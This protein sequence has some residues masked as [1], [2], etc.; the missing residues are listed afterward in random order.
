MNTALKAKSMGTSLWFTPEEL[1]GDKNDMLSTLIAC[2]QFS[3]CFNLLEYTC[4]IVSDPSKKDEFDA[5]PDDL[6][7][8]IL[9]LHKKLIKDWE[10]FNKDPYFMLP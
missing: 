2:G 8:D 1:K 7:Q 3:A 6:R 10:A 4:K 9:N 5:Y